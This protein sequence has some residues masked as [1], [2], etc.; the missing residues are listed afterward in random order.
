MNTFID[1]SFFLLYHTGMTSSKKQVILVISCILFVLLYL[2]FA[3]SPADHSL[4]ITP[5][6]TVNVDLVTESQ[7]P[8]EIQIPFKLGQRLGYFTPDGKILMTESFP[9][10]ATI[11]PDKWATYTQSARNTPFYASDRTELGTISV[12]GF[13]FF[14]DSGSFIF[15]PGGMAFARL[16]EDGSE[17]WSYEY[18]SPITSFT[19]SAAGCTAG[20]AD[21]RLIDFAVDGSIV[22][23]TK[24]GGSDYEVILG[25]AVSDSGE[26]T[27]CISG[28][29]SQR[30]VLYKTQAN[31][32]K[33]VY[34]EYLNGN[35]REQT[36]VK[37]SES[38]NR[39]FAN[40]KDGLLIVDT[41]LLTSTHIPIQGKIL[42][43]KE[44]VNT[45]LFAVLT[46]ENASFTIYLFEGD[47]NPLGSFSFEASFACISTDADSLYVG[48]ETEITKLEISK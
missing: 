32:T 23:S 26:Y 7:D 35:L 39:V 40:E 4:K 14:T 17:A 42:D 36:F 1:Y 15:L 25:S 8:S 5:V 45:N 9:Y 33:T 20:Y 48:R 43:I 21:G 41:E 27:A 12:T 47:S 31:Q 16:N 13:P 46:R 30:F 6:W 3:V 28:L 22:F 38:K 10:M 24:P 2:I 44:L 29:E 37:F 18:T 11:S 19:D 34:H